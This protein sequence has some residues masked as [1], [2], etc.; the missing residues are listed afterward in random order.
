MLD[1]RYYF[2]YGSNLSK[3]QMISRCPDSEY[4]TPGKLLDYRWFIYSR[5]YANIKYSK[6]DYVLGE[7]FSLTERDELLLDD[8]E[9][10]HKGLYRKKTLPIHTEGGCF[11]CL[12]YVDPIQEVGKPKLE[13]IE[14]INRGLISAALPI[15]YVNKYIRPHIP[16]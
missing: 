1:S 13:Y 5:G 9:N 14:R 8:C 3:D 16:I 4:L 7:L 6:E 12:V 15:D 11:D 10:V 2:A